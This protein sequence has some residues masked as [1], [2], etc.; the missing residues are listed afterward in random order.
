MDVNWKLFLAKSNDLEVIGELRYVRDKNISLGLNQTGSC[1]FTMRIDDP[2]AAMLDPWA[3][4]IIAQRNDRVI[5]SGPVINFNSTTP[6]DRVSVSSNG[7]FERLNHRYLLGTVTYNDQD[8]GY[9][10]S[11]L[12][13]ISNNYANT[14]IVPGTVESTQLRT[15]TYPIDAVIGQEIQQLAE[16]ESGFDWTI[17]PETRNFDIHAKLGSIKDSVAFQ[18]NTGVKNVASADE[19][20]DGS[21]MT[22]DIRARGKFATG[23]TDDY[24]SKYKYG[25]LQD[26]RVL[27]DVPDTNILLAYTGAE[28]I[29]R[30]QPR[31][32]Y[33]FVPQRT[34]VP[35][36]PRPFD[37]Y[38]I[39]DVV[40]FSANRGR[41]QVEDQA[42]RIFAI[43][44]SIGDDGS[45]HVNKLQTSAS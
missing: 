31:V 45:E 1:G 32:V 44:I 28:I 43:D 24:I 27:S 13:T 22:N 20:I 39:G 26:V 37:D 11:Q 3:T 30:S 16:V 5:W 15:R 14:F 9:I 18:Y 7:W 12:L 42:V 10:A 2:L 8:A 29:Y 36:V 33:S 19:S 40:S 25:T 34:G 23:F 35:G 38:N 6:N 4:C 41:I 17:N 21:I